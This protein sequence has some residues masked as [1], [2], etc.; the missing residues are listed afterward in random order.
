MLLN[1][2]ARCYGVAKRSNRT[3]KGDKKKRDNR[4]AAVCKTKVP[5]QPWPQR[6]PGLKLIIDTAVLQLDQEFGGPL[7][8]KSRQVSVIHVNSGTSVF[9]TESL[10]IRTRIRLP[11]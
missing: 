7:E 8:L 1:E 3:Q 5:L 11:N 10:V 6:W 9:N 4:P 2:S